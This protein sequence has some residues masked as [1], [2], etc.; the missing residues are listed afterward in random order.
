MIFN[1]IPV[2][3]LETPLVTDP[4]IPLAVEL[5][6]VGTVVPTLMDAA[7]LSVAI[8]DGAER[9]LA[10]F[11]DSINV[12][13]PSSS[14]LLPTSAENERFVVPSAKA[15]INECT[16]L[17]PLVSCCTLPVTSLEKLCDRSMD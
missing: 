8:T 12:T 9:T 1:P 4:V 16:V 2:A 13:V 10:R 3:A 11:C 5:E 6:S 14:R 15:P 17:A 7:I